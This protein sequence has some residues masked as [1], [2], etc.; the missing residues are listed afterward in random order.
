MDNSLSDKVVVVTGGNSGI[1]KAIADEYSDLGAK[2]V[3]FGR[4]EAKLQETLSGLKNGYAVK[5]DVRNINDLDRLFIEI[6]ARF[7]KI[8]TLIANAGCGA[9]KHISLV[10]E[11]FY[12][13]IMDTNVKGVYFT[14]QRSLEYLESNASVILISSIAGRFTWPEHSVYSASKAAVS[15]LAKSFASDLIEKGIRVNSI[16]PGFTDTPI[17]DTAKK[18]KPNFV[19]E[20]QEAIPNKRFAT[21]SEIAKAAVFLSSQNA[22]YIIGHDIVIDGGMSTIFPKI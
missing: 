7:G 17:L 10:D 16:S 8:S 6:N 22:E 18:E 20:R 2:V 11:Q 21:P 9:T 19:K 13:E 3:I 15:S 5:G 12:N 14:V 1:G 4:D